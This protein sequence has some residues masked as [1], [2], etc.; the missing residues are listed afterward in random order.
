MHEIKG[1]NHYRI[2]KEIAEGGM[3]T[4][5]EAFQLGIQGFQKRVAIKTLLSELYEDERFIDM[6][7]D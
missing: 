5:Y 1:I 7:I 6:F 4:V 2:T 3:G